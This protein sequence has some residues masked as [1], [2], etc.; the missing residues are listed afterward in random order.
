[1]NGHVQWAIKVQASL[2]L[3]NPEKTASF[4]KYETKTYKSAE[5]LQCIPF[6]WD[7]CHCF[8]SRPHNVLWK[9]IEIML[10]EHG[11][12][13]FTQTCGARASWRDAEHLLLCS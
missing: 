9:C 5:Q 4:N 13:A 8:C 2:I 7:V 3:Y 12:S 10:R 11:S 6:S 1:M